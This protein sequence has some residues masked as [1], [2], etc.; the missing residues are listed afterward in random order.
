VDIDNGVHLLD[1]RLKTKKKV[2]VNMT[3]PISKDYNGNTFEYLN[4]ELTYEV[5]DSTSSTSAS[6]STS[7]TS[8]STS[9]SSSHSSS[10]SSSSSSSTQSSTSSS[11]SSSSTSS[12]DT[13]P[14][15]VTMSSFSQGGKTINKHTGYVSIFVTHDKSLIPLKN[16]DVV[17]LV[18]LEEAM[19]IEEKIL[20][21]LDAGDRPSA[22]QYGISQAEKILN[23]AAYLTNPSVKTA[24]RRARQQNAYLQ[25]EEVSVQQNIKYGSFST[26]SSIR[27]DTFH[28]DL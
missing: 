5:T 19:K 14:E 10:H 12:S 20:E 27:G 7:A 2:L 28:D 11:S 22:I 4:W 8:A 21:A 17:G 26:G 3:V 23:N 15:T 16:K 18:E 24:Y 13:A 6:S 25:D 1:L 9:T